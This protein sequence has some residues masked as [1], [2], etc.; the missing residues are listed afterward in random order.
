M[1]LS[2]LNL[3]S[4]GPN[5]HSTMVPFHVCGPPS[6]EFLYNLDHAADSGIYD[7]LVNVLDH[8]AQ[9]LYK[10]PLLDSQHD[11]NINPPSNQGIPQ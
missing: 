7:N 9:H 5:Q 4:N 6:P 2:I 10:D 1:A 3:S 11:T 8:N